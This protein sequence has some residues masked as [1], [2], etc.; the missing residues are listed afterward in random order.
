MLLVPRYAQK[1][2]ITCWKHCGGGKYSFEG[3]SFTLPSLN[4]LSQGTIVLSLRK[5]EK[6]FLAISLRNFVC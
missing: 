6:I 5:D 2:N 3:V 4:A 1:F